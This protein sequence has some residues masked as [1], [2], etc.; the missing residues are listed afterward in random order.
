MK[1]VGS[2]QLQE[3]VHPLHTPQKASNLLDLNVTGTSK[4]VF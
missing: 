1:E 3:M 2:R 4:K